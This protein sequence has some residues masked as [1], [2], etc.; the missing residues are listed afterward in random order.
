MT[1]GGMWLHKYT[2]ADQISAFANDAMRWA[3]E[4]ELI[5]GDTTI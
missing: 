5:T 2:D 3:N 1:I 4:N